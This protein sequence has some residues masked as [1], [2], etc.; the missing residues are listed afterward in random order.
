[1]W[2][3]HKKIFMFELVYEVRSPFGNRSNIVIPFLQLL[4]CFEDFYRTE[5]FRL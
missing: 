4:S 3:P 1:M 2:Q 5:I